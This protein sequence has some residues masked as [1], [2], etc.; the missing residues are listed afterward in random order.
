M[1]A[2]QRSAQGPG[3]RDGGEDGRRDPAGPERLCERNLNRPTVAGFAD[4][5]A[6]HGLLD[7]E[8]LHGHDLHEPA[9]KVPALRGARGRQPRRERAFA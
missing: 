9:P 8:F 4:D 1:T 6:H 5:F 3:Q 2:G 7:D